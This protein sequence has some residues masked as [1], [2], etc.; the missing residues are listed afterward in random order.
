[1]SPSWHDET[2]VYLAPHRLCAV[3]MRRGWRPTL[4][5]EHEQNVAAGEPAWAAPLAALDALLADAAWRGGALRMVLADHWGRY[6]VVPWMAGLSSR[7]ERLGH[8]RQV[9]ASLYGDAVSDWELALSDTPP[10]TAQL[11]C[12]IPAVLIA[13]VR[14]LAAKHGM[15]LASLQPNLVAAFASWRAVLPRAGAWF[16]TLEQGAL[17]AVHLGE[18]GFDRVHGVRIGSDWTREMKRVQTFGRLASS[19]PQEGAVYVDAPLAWRY[20]AGDAA[21]KGLQWLEEGADASDTLAQLMRVR[22]N[23]A[24]AAAA[25]AATAAA[26]TVEHAA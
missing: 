18:G 2:G 22:R 13:Q 15:R 19:N 17:A 16:V 8:A 11:A 10:G 23:G 1:M 12:T 4:V 14:E 6:A 25:T 20:V 26:G 24:V 3:R 7:A 9:L 21:G 5:A